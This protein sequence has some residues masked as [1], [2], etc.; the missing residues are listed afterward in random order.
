[1]ERFRPGTA[2]EPNAEVDSAPA[3]AGACPPFRKGQALQGRALCPNYAGNGPLHVPSIQNCI[4]TYLRA[5]PTGMLY[6]N[7]VVRV[8]G[9]PKRH[10][11]NMVFKWSLPLRKGMPCTWHNFS[12]YSVS[13]VSG[14]FNTIETPCLYH[15]HGIPFRRCCHHLH[16][17]VIC[18]YVYM[19]I[20]IYVYMYICIYVYMYIC[21][22]VY[23]YIYD[24]GRSCFRGHRT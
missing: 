15:L 3:S 9:R 6:K 14:H 21:I 1:M 17:I 19:Y 11:I 13:M 18:I 7:G 8:S 24:C 22:Y 20:C 10:A 2:V 5:V 16:T 4:F 12:C 23:M